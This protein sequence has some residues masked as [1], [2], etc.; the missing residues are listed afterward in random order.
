MKRIG[1]I[2]NNM[3]E[4]FCGIALLSTLV[5]LF[6]NV[7]LRYVFQAST[8]WAEELIRYLMVWIA[9]IGCSICVRKG[10]HV[11]IDFFLQFVNT[12]GKILINRIV[13]LI[14][15]IFC[16]LMT[17]YAWQLVQFNLNT[18]QVTPALG[19]PM[20][21]PYLA[22]PVGFFLMTVRFFQ[23]MINPLVQ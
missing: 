1:A 11:G 3:E 9:F 15:V 10:I 6:F 18:G 2:F 4:Y 8:T 21:I 5:I 17:Y 20:Y 7:V 19:I 12:T 14:C 23:G 13:N 22:A 16:G